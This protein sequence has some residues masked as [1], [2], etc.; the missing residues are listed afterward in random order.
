M[1]NERGEERS[2]VQNERREGRR[3][4]EKWRR[5]VEEEGEKEIREG[6]GTLVGFK[7]HTDA[8][9]NFFRI[10]FAGKNLDF[11]VT[12]YSLRIW[13][14]CKSQKLNSNNKFCDHPF[15]IFYVF[16]DIVCRNLGHLKFS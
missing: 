2:E 5:S 15:D 4:V 11:A 16:S 1:E 3:E 13:E 9:Q 6:E 14:F 12:F 7:I 10:F 8:P